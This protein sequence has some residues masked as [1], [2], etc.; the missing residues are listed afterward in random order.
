MEFGSS[1]PALSPVRWKS[2]E[3]STGRMIWYIVP[4]RSV[5]LKCDAKGYVFKILSN[6]NINRWPVIIKVTSVGMWLN[7][8]EAQK[9]E[10]CLKTANS[11]LDTSTT[12]LSS[13]WQTFC[14]LTSA[15]DTQRSRVRSI[16]G[17]AA[18]RRTSPS[19]SQQQSRARRPSNP[20]SGHLIRVRWEGPVIITCRFMP[21]ISIWPSHR[22][23]SENHRGTRPRGDRSCQETK[24]SPPL[25]LS[26]G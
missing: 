9:L 18:H 19:R 2:L 20:V 21:H 11:C 26:R 13:I 17:I 25:S 6:C 23:Q 7:M 1:L 10:N 12:W 15:T 24:D 14:N 8:I 3:K 16:A 22:C 4:I 5:I